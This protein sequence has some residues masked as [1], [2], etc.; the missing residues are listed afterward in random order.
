MLTRKLAASLIAQMPTRKKGAG[1]RWDEAN[2][3]ANEADSLAADRM[4]ILEP[5][6]PF[7]YL[8][9]DGE[10]E[11]FPPMAA[12]ATAAPRPA[13]PPISPAVPSQDGR[14]LQP[15]MDLSALSATALERRDEGPPDDD[16]EKKR[17][18]EENRK[19]HYKLGGGLAQ[20]RAQAQMLGDDDDE[21]EDEDGDGGG[22]YSS[23]GAVA[24]GS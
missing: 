21:D 5:K 11:A 9:D 16:V 22:V 14:Q 1:L 15:G 17:K 6:T 19:N 20:L 18:F 7:H 12:P 23:D 3:E 24:A 13:P 4:K 2:L 8:G 10:P